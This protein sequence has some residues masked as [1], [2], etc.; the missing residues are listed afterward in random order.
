[1]GTVRQI[2][3]ER[4]ALEGASAMEVLDPSNTSLW[5]CSKELQSG[6]LMSD[7]VGKNE[8]TKVVA[9]LQKKGAGAPQREPIVSESEQKA[10]IA[11]YHK[12][13]QEAE[14]MNLEDE[15]SYMNSAWA[16][17]KGLKNAFSG[18]GEIKAFAGQR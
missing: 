18:I 7:F 4:E 14:Q 10:M 17:P 3:E 1:M 15:D 6:K 13:Q 12:K 2:L 5:C 9:K 11:F 8:K 16:N